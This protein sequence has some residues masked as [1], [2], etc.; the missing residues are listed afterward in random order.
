MAFGSEKKCE[1]KESRYIRLLTANYV[2]IKSF[3]F[4]MLPNEADADDV[5]QD[6]SITMWKKFD[7][8]IPETDFAAWAV[9]IAKYKV[10]EFRRRNFS[11]SILV[12]NEVL[13][14]LAKD[15]L[16]VFERSQER[17][18][19]LMEC[20]KELTAGDQDFIKLKYSQGLTL[21]KLASRFGLSVTSAFRN[22]ARIHGL[23]QSCVQRKMRVEAGNV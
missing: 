5:M 4:S 21:K 10:M 20:V 9:T 13:E 3:I 8:Y 12:D 7:T 6:A 2:R 11:N 19:K 18:E 16:Q 23:L 17:T 22:N 15:N 14:L 1:D